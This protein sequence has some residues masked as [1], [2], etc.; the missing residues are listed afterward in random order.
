MLSEELLI[1]ACFLLKIMSR[2]SVLE[3]FS[4]FSIRRSPSPRNIDTSRELQGEGS[5]SILST[6]MV[7]TTTSIGGSKNDLGSFICV[8]RYTNPV[9]FVKVGRL[10]LR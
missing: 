2:N 10:L 1:L 7:D 9:N 3:E 5:R 8:Q 6:K 4:V